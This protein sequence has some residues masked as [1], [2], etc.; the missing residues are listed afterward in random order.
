MTH[1]LS[2]EESAKP[3]PK[4]KW[5]NA[6]RQA[7][8]VLLCHLM[9][10]FY[11]HRLLTTLHHLREL[12]IEAQSKKLAGHTKRRPITLVLPALYA[13]VKRPALKSIVD[14]LKQ[15]DYV[16]NVVISMNRMS[17]EELAHAREFF[18]ELPQNHQIIWNDGP[19][20]NELYGQLEK[21]SLTSYI[22]GKGYN[23]WMAIGHTIA[24]GGTS[25]IATHD[26]DIISYHREMLL[27]LCMPAATP[28]IGYSFCKSYY[29]R[30]SDR[31]YGRVTRLFM[32]PLIRA[33]MKVLGPLPLLEFLDSFRY[34]LSGEFAMNV[35]LASV[36]RLPGNWGLEV[37][38][39]CEIYHNTTLRQVCQ[40]D[41]GMNF[42]HKHQHLE[43]KTEGTEP[44]PEKGLMKMAKEIVLT[45]YSNLTADG[46]R[47]DD[48]TLRTIRLTYV[49][50][51]KDTIQR[52]HDDSV[53]NGLTY[54]RHEE[55]AAIE[56]FERAL[57]L[58][59]NEFL[60]NQYHH[61]EIPNW[62]RVFSALP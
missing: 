14:E 16:N 3:R 35:N 13:E 15:V 46:V 31:M 4:R 5:D 57:D 1:F 49:K 24:R 26:T 56:A 27:R 59:D 38:M 50:T 28:S 17:A 30:V 10:D 18:S 8:R 12:D 62:N 44:S 7:R 52:F 60:G 9:A 39:L 34:L 25:I 33:M 36:L 54:Y 37:G 51:A 43:T 29:G 47:L 40:V 41:L 20:L 61:P 45:L 53:V 58:A 42:E 55:A 21:N 48:T 32:G 6:G 2:I 19:R 11:Q 22:P 23:V